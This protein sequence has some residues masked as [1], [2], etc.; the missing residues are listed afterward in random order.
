MN[1]AAIG[2]LKADSAAAPQSLIVVQLPGRATRRG[3]WLA[4]DP[5]DAAK[6]LAWAE[7]AQFRV[8]KRYSLP[9]GR[10]YALLELQAP[11]R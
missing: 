7:A 11:S 8:A 6:E 2:R 1:A 4:R 10:R 5:P 9:N 3:R